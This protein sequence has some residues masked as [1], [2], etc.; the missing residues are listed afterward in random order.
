M[1]GAMSALTLLRKGNRV[2]LIDRWAPGHPRASSS[3]YTRVFRMIHGADK[4]YTSWAR[5]ARL[6]WMELQ[7]ETGSKLFV[8][9]GALVLATEG[10]ASWEDATMPVFDE[11]SIP[12]FKFDPEELSI[13]FPQ[14]DFRNIAYGIYE[15]ESGAVMAHRAVV[16]TVNLFEREGGT[17]L[18]GRV[19]TD[20][21]E[22]LILNGRPLEADLIVATAGPWLAYLFPRTVAPI[23]HI[24]RQNIIYTSTPDSDSSFDAENMPAWIDHGYSAYGAPSVDGSGVKAAIAWTETIIDL[25]NDPRIVDEATFLRTR[26]YLQN[27]F[28]KLAGQKA[29][30]QKSC[31]I[32]MTPD[33]HF[34][35]DF[36]P[37][38]KNVLIVG[39]CSGHLF[40]HGP[41]LGEFVAGVGL[42]EFGTA[43]RFQLNSRLKL[44]A[45]DSPSGR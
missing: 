37:V 43:E 14:F 40:K 30:D 8:E 5:E 17:L 1:A 44:S 18:R 36:H 25:D 39:G 31:Q 16:E 6:R 2:T 15:P 7:E 24:V 4:M 20:E 27:R 35:I 11:L 34:I 45:G 38:H 42:G 10:E 19:Y 28:P 9:C 13:R 23:L 41:V 3:D 12:Y 22:Q 26:Q 29:V 32:A 21:S 33:T